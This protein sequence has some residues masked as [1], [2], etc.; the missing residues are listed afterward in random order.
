[1]LQQCYTVRVTELQDIELGLLD[2]LKNFKKQL[3]K[4]ESS[5]YTNQ[6]SL[7]EVYELNAKLEAEIEARTKELDTANQQMLTLQHIWD[8]MNSSKP[9]DSVLNAIAGSLQGE[10]GYLHSCIVKKMVDNEGEYLKMLAHSGDLFDSIF[11][12]VYKCEAEEMRFVM[13]NEP[14]LIDSIDCD[15][16]FQ[17]DDVVNLISTSTPVSKEIVII[18]ENLLIQQ[19]TMIHAIRLVILVSIIL[20]RIENVIC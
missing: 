10:L 5:V 8:M 16:I 2:N 14:G 1:M 13:P 6:K 20:K 15:E 17:S 19:K 9:L 4:V 12:R 18:L 7:W 3:D 11:R